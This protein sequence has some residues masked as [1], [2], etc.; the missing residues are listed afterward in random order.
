[1]YFN[2]F[3][4]IGGAGVERYEHPCAE[5]DAKMLKYDG[6]HDLAIG[7]IVSFSETDIC[8]SYAVQAIIAP[9]P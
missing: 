4:V 2:T 1:M 8:G 3:I 6:S 7:S 9:E 5:G